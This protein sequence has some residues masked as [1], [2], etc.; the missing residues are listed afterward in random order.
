MIVESSNNGSTQIEDEKGLYCV[1]VNKF[2]L[3]TQ[4]SHIT[5]ICDI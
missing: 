4:N 1:L 2:Y 3:P 5:G